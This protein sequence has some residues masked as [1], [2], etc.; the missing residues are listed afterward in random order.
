MR[1]RLGLPEYPLVHFEYLRLDGERTDRT[2]MLCGWPGVR[3][4]LHPPQDVVHDHDPIHRIVPGT[5]SE[6]LQFAG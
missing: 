2:L 6:S 1:L 4:A 5:L 3:P